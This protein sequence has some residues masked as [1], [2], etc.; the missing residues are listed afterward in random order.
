VRNLLDHL[1]LHSGALVKEVLR[2][3]NIGRITEVLRLL[4]REEISMRH[5]RQILEALLEWAPKEKD[6]YALAE[7]TRV[8]LKRYISHKYATNNQVSAILLDP[9]V[10]DTLRKSLKQ[11]GS[12]AVF[13]L[14]AD[15]GLLFVQTL[16]EQ[17]D[18]L[19]K[20]G[21]SPVL[22]VQI[23]LRRAARRQVESSLPGLAVVAFQELSQDI[24][25][26]P[27]ATLLLN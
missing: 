19:K 18:A 26:Q 20:Q 5:L 2:V 11:T 17:T 7:L 21:L 10:E 14:P 22:V 8:G 24:V 12:G 9:A 15:Y 6:N 16:R 25:I 1:E 13:S 3:V 23:D 27:K 4:I